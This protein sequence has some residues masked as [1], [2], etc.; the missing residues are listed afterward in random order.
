MTVLRPFIILLAASACTADTGP[1]QPAKAPMVLTLGEIETDAAGR[2]F[3]LTAPQTRTEIVTDLI[4]VVPAVRDEGGGVTT[5]AI[6][7]KVTRPTVVTAGPGTRL[8]TV[9]PPIYTESFVASLQRALVIRRAYVGPI[10]GVYDPLTR[11]AVRDFQRGS[12]VDSP[13]LAVDTA[14]TLGIFAV[15]RS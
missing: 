9:C 12:G 2:C 1:A 15:P 10:S 14:R 3:A 4:E 6:L 7:R 13:L 11:A 5:P 8:E